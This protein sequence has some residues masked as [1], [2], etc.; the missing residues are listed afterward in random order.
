MDIVQ[1]LQ[2]CKKSDPFSMYTV[3][4][5]KQ[6][7]DEPL[8]LF[9]NSLIIFFKKKYPHYVFQSVSVEDFSIE[10]LCFKLHY[11]FLG[12]P[13]LFWL[14][15][16]Q[17]MH[18]GD[19]KKLFDFLSL[20]Q[21]RNK[22]IYLGEGMFRSNVSISISLPAKVLLSD[23]KEF[24]HFYDISPKII[25]TYITQLRKITSH[26]SLDEVCNLMSYAFLLG[27]K[28]EH[29]LS[30]WT[31]LLFAPD[32]SLFL[33]S[34]YFFAK[35]SSLFFNYWA[36]IEHH[37]NSSFWTVFW[38]EQLWRAA[39]FVMLK[40]MNRSL[41]A[42]KIAY[43]IPFSFINNDWRNYTFEE[44]QN[45]HSYL[46]LLE[47]MLKNGASEYG[48]E[49]FYMKFLLNRFIEYDETVFL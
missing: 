17:H 8:S 35:K 13:I 44:L 5:L 26:I 29:F 12:S 40:K 27:V 41:D 28:N 37:Y 47:H 42:Q 22:I 1:F 48:L 49:L 20:Y 18:S 30:E 32:A 31:L 21:G 19:Q 15:G 33:L 46:C 14:K 4:G 25:A 38:S 36:S 39:H 23:V 16:I 7:Q 11:C 34:Q 43:K 3:I 9:F 2:L 45:A 6:E 10:E 24:C